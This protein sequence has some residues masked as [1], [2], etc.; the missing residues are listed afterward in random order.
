[1]WCGGVQG[2]KGLKAAAVW[3]RDVK[4]D[5]VDTLSFQQLQ[6]SGQVICNGDADSGT[7]R[8]RV[9]QH[10]ANQ[11]CVARPSIVSRT[12]PGLSSTRRISIGRPGD[13]VMFRLLGEV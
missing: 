7:M 11:A 12:S 8:A 2:F 1:L 3:Q 6:P 13:L 4:E 5:Q 9:V 10:L